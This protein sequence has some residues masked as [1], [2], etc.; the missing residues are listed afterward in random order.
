M[1]F[2]KNQFSLVVLLAS[3]F[4]SPVFAQA[5]AE[6]VV[7]EYVSEMAASGVVVALG[8]KTVSGGTV[9]WKDVTMTTPQNEG[10]YKIAFIRAEEIGGDKVSMTYPKSV[11]FKID[12]KGEQPA[13]DMIMTL[14][15][16]THIISGTKDARNHDFSAAALNMLMPLHSSA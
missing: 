3:S 12:P 5:L 4:A 13:M 11:S 7:Q 16:M 6:E 10:E 9:E 14:R 15:D 2:Y 8:A 1:S